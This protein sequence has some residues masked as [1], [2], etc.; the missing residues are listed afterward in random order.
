MQSYQVEVMTITDIYESTIVIDTRPPCFTRKP[1]QVY[2]GYHNHSERHNRFD[3]LSEAISHHVWLAQR[4]L[5]QIAEF[6]SCEEPSDRISPFF[7]SS[8]L[9]RFD[10]QQESEF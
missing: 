6:N 9:V 1:Y 7:E 10:R 5:N 4:Y 3:T 8:G 2:S